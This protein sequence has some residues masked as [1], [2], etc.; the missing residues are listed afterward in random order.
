[1]NFLKSVLFKKAKITTF[2]A[3]LEIKEF[4]PELFFKIRTQF[5]DKAIPFLEWVSN[6]F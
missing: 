6:V 2:E 4:L 3:L 5:L 1:M